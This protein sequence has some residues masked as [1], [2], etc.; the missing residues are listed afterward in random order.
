MDAPDKPG[1][2][3][4]KDINGKI[5]YIGKAKNLKKR[6]NSYFQKRDHEPKTEALVENID[7]VEY[8]V[9]D[10]EVEALILESNLIKKNQPK[11]NI[12]LKDSKRFAFIELT[13]EEFPRLLTARKIGKGTYFGPFTSGSERNHLLKLLVRLFQLR[14][15]KRMP[16]KPCLRYH[17]NLCT[18]PCAGFV[19]EDEYTEQINRARKVLSGKTTALVKELRHDM[20]RASSQQEYEKAMLLRDQISALLYLSEKQ[21]M[22]RQKKYDED[23]IN[24]LVKDSKVYLMLFN[25]HKGTLVNK[26]EFMFD[27][28]ERFL[29]QFITQ[30]YSE[31]QV[32]KE[33]IVPISVDNSIREFL[34]AKRKTK[35]A[36]MVPKIGIKKKLLELVHVNIQT[37]FFGDITKIEE[38]QKKLKLN[39]M[40]NVIECIDISHLGG[41]STVGSM[42][43][44]RNAKPDKSNYRRF[45]IRTVT[46]IDDYT[47]IAEVVKRRYYRLKRENADMPD[48][49]VID[50]GKGQLSAALRELQ[51]LRLKIPIISI[52]KKFE[53]I[54]FPGSRFALRLDKK[55]KA[56]RF[57]QE[58]RDEAHRFAINYNRLL[59]KKQSLA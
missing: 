19:K 28:D 35:V 7:T 14:T 58:I 18:A 36:V 42:V 44:F 3:L 10:S 17:I 50:G 51:K 26:Q 24:Y 2:Y 34:K 39:D 12:N 55:E 27:A 46:E 4:F 15:C 48:L 54:Y 59:R 1:C 22:E 52:A 49:I 45:R 9:T 8:I 21:K 57:L 6:V 23:I 43:Q 29:E 40:P 33:L 13:N 32:P 11:Y 47:A 38:L 16:K 30:F 53:E 37:T 5:L 41:T 31:Q 20:N 56:L 25:I